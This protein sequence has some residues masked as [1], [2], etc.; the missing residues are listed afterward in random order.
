MGGFLLGNPSC[1]PH[2]EPLAVT[3][4]LRLA[5]KGVENGVLQVGGLA[6]KV[7]EALSRVCRQLVEALAALAWKCGAGGHVM[8]LSD[9]EI[10]MPAAQST[11]TPRTRK[12]RPSFAAT[13]AYQ[14]AVGVEEA[15]EVV[16]VVLTDSL[17]EAHANVAVLEATQV[18]ARGVGLLV[19]R[20]AQMVSALRPTRA[21][22]PA[23]L[24]G[25]ATT[26]ADENLLLGQRLGRDLQGVKVHFA[27]QLVAEGLHGW[28]RAE[29]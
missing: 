12:L 25:V 20:V 24:L 27:A 18:D 16:E 29:R 23:T 21:R 15:H 10:K 6:R 11:L 26:Y 3:H 19:R 14:V 2:L 4:E 13:A 5:V 7:V 9:V 8:K 1:P 22:F 17:V 28:H